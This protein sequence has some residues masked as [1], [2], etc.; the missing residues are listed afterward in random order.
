MLLLSTDYTDFTDFLF[1][2]LQKINL[3]N[4]NCNPP[5]LFSHGK[6]GITR[7]NLKK[8]QKNIFKMFF[9]YF[10]RIPCFSVASVANKL[11]S[12]TV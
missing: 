7:K 3:Y 10:A 4:S 5:T 2:V 6:H 1:F 9:H 11:W 8:K 12:F